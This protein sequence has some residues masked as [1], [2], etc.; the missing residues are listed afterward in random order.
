MENVWQYY[1]KNS[2]ARAPM[3]SLQPERCFPGP[4]VQPVH[5]TTT[6]HWRFFQKIGQQKKST[7]SEVKVTVKLSGGVVWIKK[8]WVTKYARDAPDLAFRKA[9]AA[10]NAAAT[11]NANDLNPS[12]SSSSKGKPKPQKNCCQGESSERFFPIGSEL[13]QYDAY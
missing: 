10:M 6:H 1:M 13:G 7:T 11:G 5:L 8:F 9:M 4:T 3:D 2:G 12:Q